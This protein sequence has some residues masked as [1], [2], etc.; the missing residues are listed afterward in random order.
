MWNKELQAWQGSKATKAV[1]VNLL[2][3]CRKWFAKYTNVGEYVVNSRYTGLQMA[4]RYF[5]ASV[6]S[7]QAL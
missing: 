2:C 1:F 7:T 5:K 6:L 3:F 4:L